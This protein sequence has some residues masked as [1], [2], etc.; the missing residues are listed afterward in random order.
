MLFKEILKFVLFSIMVEN[1]SQLTRPFSRKG[2]RGLQTN[3]PI[4]SRITRVWSGDILQ[5]LKLDKK[6][7]SIKKEFKID[8]T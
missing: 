7:K 6:K 8:T 1:F 4:I 2:G 5:L 3:E